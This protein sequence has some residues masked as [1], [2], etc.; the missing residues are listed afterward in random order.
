MRTSISD[1]TTFCRCRRKWKYNSFNMMNII[2]N[3]QTVSLFFGTGIHFAL[4]NYYR[5]GKDPVETYAEWYNNHKDEV[6]NEGPDLGILGREMLR[7]Y[8]TAVM[9]QDRFEV[10]HVEYEFEYPWGTNIYVGKMDGIVRDKEG[11]WV[12]EHKTYTTPPSEDYWVFDLQTVGYPWVLTQLVKLG[13]VQG[14]DKSETVMGVIYNGLRKKIP[15]VPEVLKSGKSLSKNVAID[16]TKDVYY[17]AILDNGF[18]PNDYH[19]ILLALEARGNSFFRRVKIRRSADEYR[20]FELMLT[21]IGPEM[22]RAKDEH[23]LYPTLTPE[24]KTMCNYSTICASEMSNGDTLSII[25]SLYRKQE[26][27]EVYGTQKESKWNKLKMF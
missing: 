5:D 3:K 17:K 24:C 16:T 21:R 6:T 27:S 18:S 22:V 10:V 9:P 20:H 7:H 15:T 1:I 25:K 11:I 14:I 19:D 8:T 4:E 12:L 26:R 2:P 23:I 13:K